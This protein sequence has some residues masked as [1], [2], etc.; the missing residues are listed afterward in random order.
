MSHLA[1]SDAELKRS[2]GVPSIVKERKLV[3]V[4][5]AGIVG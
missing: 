4:L 5:K 1:D 2:E 3:L